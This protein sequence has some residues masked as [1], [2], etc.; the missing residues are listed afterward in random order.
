MSVKLS[1]WEEAVVWLRGQPEQ[2]DLVRACFY[3]DPLQAAA[4]RYYASTE[5]QAIRALIKGKRGLALDLGAGR[6]ISSYA[7]GRD[8]WRVNALEPDP[9]DVVGSGAIRALARNANLDIQV[10]QTWGESLPYPDATFDL[11][12]ARQV[13]HHARD[14]KKLCCE[15]ARVLKPGGIFIATREHVISRKDD[16]P[17]F[18]AAHPLHKMYGGEHAYLLAEYL[19]AINSGGLSLTSVLNPCQ[20]DINLFPGTKKGLKESLAKRFHCPSLLI[21]NFLLTK[22]GERDNS[23]GRLYTFVARK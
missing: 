16:L 1:S 11:V 9:S 15:A 7:L 12:H 14:L 19:E 21:P 4:E 10:E 23:P 22:L 5:W 13:L 3:D 20:S 8:G 17:V 18:L 6:G 2:R